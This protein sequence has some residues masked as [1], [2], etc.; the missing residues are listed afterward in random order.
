VLEEILAKIKFRDEASSVLVSVRSIDEIDMQT[1]KRVVDDYCAIVQ[2]IREHA[3]YEQER[4]L[5]HKWRGALPS[6]L[7]QILT[8]TK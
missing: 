6:V 8:R 2:I 1:L 4:M 7:K 5:D 3:N